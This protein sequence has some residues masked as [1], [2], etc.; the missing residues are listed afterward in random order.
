M[1]CSS[2]PARVRC[3]GI[4]NFCGG[5]HTGPDG[6]CSRCENDPLLRMEVRQAII[7][8]LGGLDLDWPRTVKHPQV[9]ELPAHLPVIV[10]AYAD[11]VDVPWVA[12]HGARLFGLSGERLTPKHHRPLREVY[13][14]GP[15]TRIAIE[16]YV[17]DRVLEGLW[18]NRSLVVAQLRELEADLVLTPNFSVWSSDSRMSQLV[19]IRRAAIYYHSLV[20]AGVPAIPDIGFY[21]FEPDGR[22]WAEW[23]NRNRDVQ[24]VS[25][26][27]GGKKIHASRRALRETLEDIA[28]FHQAVRPD[29]T[30]VLGGVHSA[31]RL[32]A[33][34]QAAP[35]RRLV[36][37]NGMAYALA[38]RR[39]A[40]G[41]PGRGPV[42]LSSRDCFLRN[43]QFNNR[44]Y[45]QALKP[46]P[47]SGDGK[48]AA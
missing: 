4:R 33:Y 3:G 32:A 2:C 17:D 27:C 42:A 48:E 14:L 20:E 8:Q 7:K 44:A 47:F 5:G 46:G 38:Q 29:V 19:N 13:R 35:G 16:F 11:R 18:R 45:E 15:R 24:A 6:T 41:Q 39:K 43:I 1:D 40:L 26:F 36:F 12:L 34:R 10:Q 30:F 25:M 31:A 9:P 37:C 28:L 22:L 21:F 23:V